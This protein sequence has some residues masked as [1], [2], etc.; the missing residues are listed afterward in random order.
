MKA[1]LHSWSAEIPSEIA[2]P[3]E[4]ACFELRNAFPDVEW[5][6]RIDPEMGEGYRV[7]P[8]NSQWVVTGGETGVL[9]G[10]YEMIRKHFAGQPAP[11]ASESAPR[12][13]LRMIN[14]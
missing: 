10:A 6:V 1:W 2:S 14:C 13:P 9:Y 4:L 5:T 11:F 3:Y 8:E 12:Y 7:Y